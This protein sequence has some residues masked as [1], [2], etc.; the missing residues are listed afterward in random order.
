MG[1]KEAKETVLHLKT[2][3]QTVDFTKLDNVTKKVRELQEERMRGKF[4]PRYHVN[5]YAFILELIKDVRL[6]VEITLNLVNALFDSVKT[7]TTGYLSREAWL[8]TFDHLEKLLQLLDTPQMREAMRLN[9]QKE[10]SVSASE[11]GLSQAD[12][13]I[14]HA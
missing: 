1:E 11:D 7:T 10:V 4:D 6:R 13:T 12:D 14:S 8:S 5:V 9:Q 2:D 3:Y